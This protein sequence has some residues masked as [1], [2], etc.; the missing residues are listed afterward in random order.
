M[1]SQSIIPLLILT[2]GLIGC[3]RTGQS[4]RVKYDKTPYDGKIFA[5]GHEGLAPAVKPKPKI[6]KAQLGH[7][8]HPVPRSQWAEGS[9]NLA[10]INPM[11]GIRRITVHHDGLPGLFFSNNFDETA[12]R[13]ELI[14]DRHR[15]NNGWADIG[16][17]FVIDR[18]GRVWE[19]R[20]L[21]Y[22]GAHVKDQN[23]NNLGILVLGNFQIQKP[24]AVQIAALKNTLRY[25]RKKYR[26]PASNIYTHGELGQTTCP[27]AHLQQYVDAIRNEPKF[28]TAARD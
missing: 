17:H 8:S 14:R 5:K 3:G 22:Q 11:N 10:N 20:S 12:S 1:K 6:A 25:F 2:F 13:I 26:V 16:Y 23:E 19:A 18:N 9:P 7:P 4:T 24:K 21:K 28:K 15:N 27:G